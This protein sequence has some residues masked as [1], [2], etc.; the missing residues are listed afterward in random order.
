MPT[1]IQTNV[2]TIP[3]IS[4]FLT[5]ALSSSLTTSQPIS[6]PT[7]AMKIGS[8][9]QAADVYLVAVPVFEA[10]AG[11]PSI[12]TPQFSQKT[13]PAEFMELQLGQVT[14]GEPVGGTGGAWRVAPQLPQNLAPASL[15]TPQLTHFISSLKVGDTRAIFRFSC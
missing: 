14:L 10:G 3:R 5:L 1:A 4:R 9:H 13:L 8:S 12:L 2:I 6:P 7:Q 15:S 11:A